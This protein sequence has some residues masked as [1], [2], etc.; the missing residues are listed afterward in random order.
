MKIELIEDEFT[1]MMKDI[2][3]MSEPNLLE[4]W[5]QIYTSGFL[6][7]K[8]FMQCRLKDYLNYAFCSTIELSKYK[9]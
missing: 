5:L 6:M 8:F 2:L 9:V 3:T 1:A 4:A 7:L